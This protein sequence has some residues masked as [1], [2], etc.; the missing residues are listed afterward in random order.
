MNSRSIKG[1]LINKYNLR[2]MKKLLATLIIISTL[3]L[4]LNSQTDDLKEVFL[5]AESYF[6]FEEYGDALSL[7]LKIH[8]AEPDNDNVNYKIGVCLLNDP[9]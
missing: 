6:L 5:E 8:R 1:R 4:L 2:Q 3:P 9:Y 7:Y